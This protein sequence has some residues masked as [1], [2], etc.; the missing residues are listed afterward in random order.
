MKQLESSYLTAAFI[1]SYSASLIAV[2]WVF[3]DPEYKSLL[4]SLAAIT[5]L[6]GSALALLKHQ[7]SGSKLNLT[8]SP[9][10]PNSLLLKRLMEG[11][12][13]AVC[14]GVSVPQT[15]ESAALSA[16]I[17]KLEGKELVCTHYWAPNPRKEQ[18]G[19]LRFALTDEVAKRIAVVRSALAKE[20]CRTPV[21]PLPTESKGVTG[22]IDSINF[23]LAAPILN[24]DLTVWGVVD[25][26]SGNDV[27]R[28]LLLNEV[29]DSVMHN[30]A[31]HLR[32]LFSLAETGQGQK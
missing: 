4:A 25:L 30:L 3:Q 18:V 9:L 32:L 23:V 22:E 19:L 13:E 14:R 1:A 31:A 28:A 10:T 26:D 5:T 20:P 12:V 8:G 29:S 21:S 16:F 24:E 15:P 17:F 6:A 11:A 7:A 2:V 27:G